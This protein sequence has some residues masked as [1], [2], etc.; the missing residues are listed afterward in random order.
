MRVDFKPYRQPLLV[1][2]AIVAC[3]AAAR[4]EEPTFPYEATVSVDSAAVHSGNGEQFYV[5]NQLPRG[6]VVRVFR[7]DPDG[8]QMIAPPEGA[9]SLVPAD[10]LEARGETSA[11]IIAPEVVARVGSQVGDE[12]GVE[13]VPL[14]FGMRV[15]RMPAQKAPEGWVAIQPPR[16]EYRWMR[17]DQLTARPADP[18]QEPTPPAAPGEEFDADGFRS[19]P[20]MMAAQKAVNESEET[21]QRLDAELAGLK[22]EDP[23]EWPLEALSLEYQRLKRTGL[24]LVQRVDDRLAQIAELKQVQNQRL[25]IA[26]TPPETFASPSTP[27]QGTEMP[28]LSAA[29]ETPAIDPAPATPSIAALEPDHQARR[30][31]GSMESADNANDEASPFGP[32]PGETPA[33]PPTIPARPAQTSTDVKP[34]DRPPMANPTSPASGTPA[35]SSDP[36]QQKPLAGTPPGN[37]PAN[38]PRGTPAAGARRFD[39]VGFIQK[40]IDAPQGAPQFVLVSSEG[41]VQAYLREPTQGSFEPYL[42]QAMGIDG[43]AQRVPHLQLPLIEV[44]RLTPVRF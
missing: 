15:E 29:P 8:W 2:I 31:S 33:A 21:L 35:E 25:G 5:T 1:T 43:R 14:R 16:G 36:F 12:F 30:P 34:S 40:A 10:S 17:G 13:Q 9:F 37:P 3:V 39:A 24:D 22:D 19:Q 11:E 41:R 20:G 26:S 18:P 23:A 32:N 38:A 42:G 44:D 6:V 4:A 28:A 27:G 7:H